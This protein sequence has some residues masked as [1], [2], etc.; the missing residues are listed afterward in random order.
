MRVP[1]GE[2]K[3]VS[4]GVIRIVEARFKRDPVDESKHRRPYRWRK[5]RVPA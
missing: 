1:E 5:I 3:P 4:E 2:V